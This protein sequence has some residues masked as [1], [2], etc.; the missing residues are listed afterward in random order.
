MCKSSNVSFEINY[1]DI[2]F[3][4]GVN[5][6]AKQDIVPGGSKR[7]LSYAKQYTNFSDSIS[8]IERLMVA[9]AQTSGGLL[10]SLPKDNVNNF[11]EYYNGKSTI[12]AF[13]IGSVNAR[14]KSLITIS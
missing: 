10:I 13:Q 1:N 14:K 8:Q 9:D 12:P 5:E 4:S 6:L 2:K 11:L 7:N 3:F